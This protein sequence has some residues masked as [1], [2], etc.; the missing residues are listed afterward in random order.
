LAVGI[1]LDYVGLRKQS[2][3][4]CDKNIARERLAPVVEEGGPLRAERN[5]ALSA[6]SIKARGDAEGAGAGDFEGEN[7]LHR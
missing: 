4:P 1:E 6:V 2:L 7:R 5:R 3:S